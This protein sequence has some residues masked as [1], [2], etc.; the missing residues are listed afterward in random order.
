MKDGAFCSNVRVFLIVRS[1]L[2]LRERKKARD[3]SLAAPLPPHLARLKRAQNQITKDSLPAFLFNLKIKKE[4]RSSPFYE[5][6]IFAQNNLLKFFCALFF[7]R[8]GRCKAKRGGKPPL[9]YDNI[10]F[11]QT[12]NRSFLPF[13]QAASAQLSKAL[14]IVPDY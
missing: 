13:W 11:Y 2:C 12:N 14:H 8:K 6:I 7:Q 3:F 5:N 4:R 1:F 10:K 9:F